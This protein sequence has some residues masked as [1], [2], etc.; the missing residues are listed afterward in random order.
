MRYAS[1][2][3]LGNAS[4]SESSEKR[5]EDL[6]MGSRNLPFGNAEISRKVL[7]VSMLLSLKPI[8]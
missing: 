1:Y 3:F 2:D 8:L 4:I 5:T 6:G 7:S